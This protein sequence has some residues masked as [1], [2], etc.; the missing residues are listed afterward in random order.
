MLSRLT[1]NCQ[2]KYMAY[3]GEAQICCDI[4]GIA[5]SSLDDK[6]DG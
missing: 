3:N 4:K 5:L 6:T 2:T 1:G